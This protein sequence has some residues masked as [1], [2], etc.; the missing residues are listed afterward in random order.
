M[1]APLILFRLV[2][3]IQQQTIKNAWKAIPNQKL[4]WILSGRP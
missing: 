3:W 4:A 1:S 2:D